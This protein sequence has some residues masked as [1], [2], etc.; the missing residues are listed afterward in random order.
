[1]PAGSVELR[2]TLPDPCVPGQ[3]VPVDVYIT[4]NY[5]ELM[6]FIKG[7]WQMTF[8]ALWATVS[9]FVTGALGFFQNLYTNLVGPGGTVPRLISSIL[10]AFSIDW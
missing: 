4:D 10:S 5:D 6:Q 3:P 2:W 1:M 9:G 7:L 8:G